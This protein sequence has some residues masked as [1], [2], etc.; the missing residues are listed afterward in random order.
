MHPYM[1]TRSEPLSLSHQLDMIL[2]N[3]SRLQLPHLTYNRVRLLYPSVADTLIGHVFMGTVIKT[4]SDSLSS[5][6]A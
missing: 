6:V 2:P 1:S 4:R 3:N 5:M